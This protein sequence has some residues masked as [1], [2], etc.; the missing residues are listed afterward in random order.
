LIERVFDYSLPMGAAPGVRVIVAGLPLADLHAWG[1]EPSGGW[2][3]LVSWIG[4][5]HHR[6]LTRSAWVPAQCVVRPAA[7]RADPR[8]VR[9]R[10]PVERAAWPLI[11]F[12]DGVRVEHLGAVLDPS[13]LA[14]EARPG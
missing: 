11:W 3:G 14:Q 7:S 9:L 13:R 10:L 6:P 4:P 12:V 2:W 5:N 1:R 8:L